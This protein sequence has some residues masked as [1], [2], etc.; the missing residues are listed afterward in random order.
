M[1]KHTH[2]PEAWRS[3]VPILALAASLLSFDVDARGSH[4]QGATKADVNAEQDRPIPDAKQ[5]KEAASDIA[6]DRDAAA[7][8]SQQD[9]LSYALGMNVGKQLRNQSVEVD[10]DLLVRGLEDARSG[11]ATLLT[12]EEVLALFKELQSDVR[13]KQIA[14]RAAKLV[15]NTKEGEAFLA[16]NKAK[17]GVVTLESG[18]QYTILTAGD[19]QR[20]TINDTVIAHYRGTLIDGTEFASSHK[21]TQPATLAI[22]KV[23]KG[24]AEA[25]QLMTVGS[26]WLLFIP[27]RLAYGERG[28]G[29]DIGPNATLMFEVELISIKHAVA[30]SA[31]AATALTGIA[32]SYKLDPRLTQG[33]YL[34]VRWVSPSTFTRV[35]DGKDLTVEA[36]AHGRDAKGR[37]LN[38]SPEWLPADPEMVSVTPSQG[39]EVTITVLRAGESTLEVASQGLSKKVHIKAEYRNNVLV[40]FFTGESP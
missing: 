32:V 26:K 13:S 22:K 36:R 14:L 11:A 21:S 39:N 27:P 23:I 37:A 30:D 15:T 20:P 38:I 29:R 33:S 24:W 34:G 2:V 18:L 4:G 10:L 40:G 3:A 17:E 1:K 5:Q 16:E 25:L 12:D 7:L 6:S 19:G 31:P 9:K 8:T 35:Q 28:A